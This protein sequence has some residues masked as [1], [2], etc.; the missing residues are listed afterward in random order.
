MSHS[1]GFRRKMRALLSKRPREHGKLGLSRL[2]HE[3][4]PGDKVVVKID[5]SVHKGM[6]HHRYQGKIGVVV[7]KRGRA[8]EVNIPQGDAVK[9][10]TVRPEHLKPHGG[11]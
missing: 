5:S 6:P 2:L 8:Y 7:A 3:Y 4:K 9:E 11:G 10:I 1:K